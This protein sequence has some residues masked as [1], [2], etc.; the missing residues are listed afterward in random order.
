MIFIKRIF[1]SKKP[2]FYRFS[3]L[4]SPK[5]LLSRLVLVVAL[6]PTPLVLAQQKEM[7]D[8]DKQTVLTLAEAVERTF[9][10]NPELQSYQ[11]KLEAQQGKIVQADLSPKPEVGLTIEDALGSGDFSGVDS[12]Q[13]TLSVSWILD[14][15]L[16]N[17]R[18][19][20]ASQGKMLIENEQA[21]QRLDSATQTAK[22]YLTALSF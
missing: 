15:S 6:I 18:V 19:N 10:S 17:E 12:A 9:A 3:R 16:K 4:K 14:Q 11:Y 20:I 21:I 1:M 13:T 2:T 7:Q 5:M 22:Y 8:K